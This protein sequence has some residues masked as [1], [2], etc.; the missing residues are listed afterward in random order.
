MD[1]TKEAI[2][3][4]AKEYCQNNNLSIDKLYVQEVYKIDDIIFAQPINIKNSDG[5]RTDLATQ[6]KPTLIYHIDTGEFEETEYTRKY[7]V[8]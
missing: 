7:L 5:L 8:D 1:I 6:P 2:F 4:K 3:Q